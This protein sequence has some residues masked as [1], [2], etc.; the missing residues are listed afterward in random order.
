MR[1]VRQK[2]AL[3]TAGV[4]RKLNGIAQKKLSVD[5]TCYVR[6]N[7]DIVRLHVARYYRRKRAP[8]R[9]IPAVAG[10]ERYIDRASGF[11]KGLY[12]LI[13]GF[14][15]N[16]FSERAY[17]GAPRKI[18]CRESE[19]LFGVCADKAIFALALGLY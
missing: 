15:I 4:L 3:C 7:A 19:H 9:N 6:C 1:H 13:R 2:L 14:F 11:G 5:I 17:S 16:V 8:E 10:L 12:D 18:A